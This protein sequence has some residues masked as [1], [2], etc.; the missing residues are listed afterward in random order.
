MNSIFLQLSYRN[1]VYPKS[2]TSRFRFLNSLTFCKFV[3]VV[4]LGNLNFRFYPKFV[5][6]KPKLYEA[7]NQLFCQTVVICRFLFYVLHHSITLGYKSVIVSFG[8]L[9]L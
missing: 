3:K 6:T 7:K 5:N 4:D 1:I 2:S 8:F 9:E